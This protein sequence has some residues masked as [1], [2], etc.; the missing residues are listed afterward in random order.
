MSSYRVRLVRSAARDLDRIDQQMRARILVKLGSL[1][2][3]PRPPDCAMLKGA[4]GYYRVWVGNY[5]VIYT[6][7]DRK[8]VIEVTGVGHRSDIYKK[9]F[10]R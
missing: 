1:A 8:H 4:H 7:K 10:D 3:D 9:N 6:V 2:E 5:R